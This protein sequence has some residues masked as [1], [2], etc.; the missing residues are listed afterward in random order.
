MKTLAPALAVALLGACGSDDPSTPTLTGTVAVVAGDFQQTG[1]F[2]TIDPDTLEVTTN[3]VAGVA[4]ADPAVRRLG[5]ELVIVNRFGGDNLTILDATTLELVAQL[6]T[7]AGSNPQDVARVGD[8]LYVP[9]LGAGSLLVIDRAADD[10]QT[11][12][13]LSTVDDDG[14]PDCVA[15]AAVADRVYVACAVLDNF[16]PVE[17]GKVVVIDTTD[18]TV[19]EVLD[20]PFANPVGW[21]EPVGDD[22]YLATVPSYTDYATGCLARVTTGAT[23]SVTCAVDNADI[24]GYL[25]DLGTHGATV[26]G[27]LYRYDETFTGSGALVT[28]ELDAGTVSDSLTPDTMLAQDLAICRDHLFLTDKATDAQGVRVF[29]LA[30]ELHEHTEAPLDVGL[31]PAFGNGLACM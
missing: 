26:Y 29:D 8:K 4:G 18:D 20:L 1:V 25:A 12:I 5:D 24:G 10:A 2:T 17:P 13:D 14:L 7:G 6:S 28:V 15:A 9:R 3:A 19:A 11:E 23:P 22:L 27:I 31:P 21:F 30:G 16:T